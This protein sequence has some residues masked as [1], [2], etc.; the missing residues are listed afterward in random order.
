MIGEALG[1]V[2]TVG[3]VEVPR[4]G[5]AGPESGRRRIGPRLRVEEGEDEVE[6]AFVAAVREG[7]ELSVFYQGGRTPWALRRFRPETL[8]RLEPGGPAY[9][10]GICR[11]RD[12]SRT[13]RLDRV[14]LG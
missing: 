11:Q 6:R 9:A 7:V 4:D 8:Y 13:L 10:E 5:M 2:V 12:A 1:K 3:L 14:R